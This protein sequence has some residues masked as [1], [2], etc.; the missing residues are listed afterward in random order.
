M[1]DDQH[2]AGRHLRRRSHAAHRKIEAARGQGDGHANAE[3]GH[4]R[5]GL[6]NAEQIVDV[7]ESGLPGGEHHNQNRQ[8]EQDA[9]T[10]QMIAQAPPC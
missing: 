5:D 9:G 1:P 8:H 2:V 10:L 6:K 3:Q 4:D 7:Q